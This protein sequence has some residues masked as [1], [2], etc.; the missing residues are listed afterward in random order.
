V[1]AED[2][3]FLTQVEKGTPMGDYLRS[4]W[5]PVMRSARVV[6][7]G[8]PIR[9]RL[10]GENFVVFRAE[11]GRAGLIDEACPHRA[12]SMA[13]GRVEGCALR[14]LYHGW[15]VDVSGEFVHLLSEA[16]GKERGPHLSLKPYTVRETGGMVWAYLGAPAD[17]PRFPDFEWTRDEAQP[18]PNGAIVHCNWVQAF[19]GLI[20]PNHVA[21]LHPQW[22]P[23]FA[24]EMMKKASIE[25]DVVD[26]PYGFSGAAVRNV[27]GMDASLVRV[28][29]Y[30][31]PWYSHIPFEPMEQRTVIFTIPID[32]ETTYLWY[33]H[34]FATDPKPT[35]LPASATGIAGHLN[36]QPEGVSTWQYGIDARLDR[37][38]NPD[39]FRDTLPFD[40][41]R[42]WEQDREAILSGEHFSGLPGLTTEDVAI[43]ESQGAIQDR[44]TERLSKN[45]T[46]IVAMRR[47]IMQRARDVAAGKVFDDSAIDYGAIRSRMGFALA[48]K[49]WRDVPQYSWDIPGSGVAKPVVAAE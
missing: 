30:A 31:M 5:V 33:V 19:E 10:F 35:N 17:A 4:Q 23:G 1:K 38:P 12:A 16:N 18:D 43:L 3:D 28:K 25:Y 9:A 40:P 36:G 46:L 14:C 2:N 15:E 20:D 22:L 7:G 6:A 32:R 29:E 47:M 45:D 24:V 21:Y 11:D 13:L 37:L 42:L 39:N 41:D 49:T 44:T 34:Y 48:G 27:P 26:T 8:A